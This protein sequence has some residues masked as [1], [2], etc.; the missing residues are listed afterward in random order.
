MKLDAHQHFWRYSASEYPWMAGRMSALR[1]DFLP[2]DLAVE[3]AKIGF[4]GS[5]AVQA[6]QSVAETRWLLELAACGAGILPA[7][8]EGVSPSC[9]AGVPPASV[10]SSVSSST[11]EQQQ[12][13]QQQDAAK[14]ATTHAGKMPGPRGVVG[15]LDLRG[16][17][18]EADLDEFA[19]NP[20]LRGLRH[21]LQDEP[22]DFM[23]RPE[24]LRG[25]G[26]LRARGLTYD[27]LI[28][29]PQLPQACELVRQFP[30]QPFV[31][32]HMA[33]P[34]IAAGELQPWTNDLRELAAAPNVC[35]KLSGLITEAD[36]RAWKP[37]DFQPYLDVA[38]DAFGPRRLMIGSDW[39]MC[40][41]AASYRQAMEIVTQYIWRLSAGE[42]ADILGRNAA[43]FYGVAEASQ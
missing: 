32:D 39:P 4:D 13:Q 14:I 5:I 11:H 35:C 28:Y 42:Q 27:I 6:R 17:R 40:T 38:L 7:C 10:A 15:W 36:W 24:F 21:V 16:D 23:L 22:D 8:G 2:A 31:L 33:K 3:Q 30:D 29:A 25:I 34:L 18:L 43:K 1:R 26:K 12:H 19:A 41:L 9:L 20:L 37:A